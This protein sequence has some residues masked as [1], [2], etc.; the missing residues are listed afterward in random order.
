VDEQPPRPAS[1]GLQRPRQH[2]LEEMSK[3]LV[4]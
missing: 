1:T 3:L 2:Y 4:T